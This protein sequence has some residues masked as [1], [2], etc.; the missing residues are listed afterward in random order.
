MNS[1]NLIQ[2]ISLK[3]NN[4]KRNANN[5]FKNMKKTI[6]VLFLTSSIT[7]TYGS[8]SHVESRGGEEFS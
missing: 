1:Y 7:E 6:K 2:I 8:V 3:E 5:L 4:Y